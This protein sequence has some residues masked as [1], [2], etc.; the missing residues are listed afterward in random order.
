MPD[1][2]HVF[3]SFDWQVHSVDATQ[4]D[5]V[6]TALEQFRYGP[7]NGKPTAIICHATK[8]YGALSDFMNRHKVVMA[9]ALMEQEIEL[10]ARSSAAS[11]WTE[12][13]ASYQAARKR[14]EGR[15]VQD[16]LRESPRGCSSNCDAGRAVR[17]HQEIGPVITQRAMPPRDNRFATT[18]RSCRRIDPAKEYAASDIVTAAMKVFARDPACGLD[19]CRPGHH[20]RARS[21]RGRGGSE[22]R[23]ERRRRRGEHDAAS[24]RHSRRSAAMP[25][26]ALFARSSTGRFC[27]ASRWAIR[28]ASKPSKPHDGWLSEGHGLDLTLLATGPEFRNSHQR[29]DPHGQRRQPDLRRHGPSEDHR[30]LVPATDSLDHEVDHGGQSRADLCPGH[31]HAFRRALWR[32][33]TSS[34]SARARDSASSADDARRHRQ[35]RTGRARSSCRRGFARSAESASGVVDMPST[36][37]EFLLAALRLRKADR[38]RRTEQRLYLAELSRRCCSLER[39]RR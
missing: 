36:D 24:A 13:G 1:L 15:P 12:F 33:T 5:G 21:G 27:A 10:Q 11:A 35:Q 26:S 32:R 8:G 19:R 30:R 14:S 23:A 4:Y 9:D 3:A 25:G 37:D 18:R 20:E 31:A 38:L 22:A 28:S 16:K 2:E 39:R 17:S 6:F 34:N 7:R 29:R